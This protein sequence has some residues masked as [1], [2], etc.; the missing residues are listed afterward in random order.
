MKKTGFLLLTALISLTLLAG[1]AK[2]GAPV[3]QTEPPLA[4]EAE[5][6]PEPTA[7]I[8]NNSPDVGAEVDLTALSSTMVYAEVYNMMMEP[9]SYVGKTVKVRGQY[10]ANYYEPTQQYYHF[11]I[12]ADATACCE[13]GLEFIWLGEHDYPEDYP[14][15]QTEIEI[16]GAFRPYDEDGHTFYHIEAD[17][18]RVL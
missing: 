16:T 3:A 4:T 5:P 15:D 18:V 1:C 10:Y 17:D 6:K 7:G 8:A 13:Q 14:K 11:L 9:E 2:G 12:I